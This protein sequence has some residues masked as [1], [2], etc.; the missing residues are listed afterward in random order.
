MHKVKPF[1]LPPFLFY[2]G[3]EK[4][5]FPFRES[6][7]LENKQVT[8]LVKSSNIESWQ[9]DIFV[10]NLFDPRINHMAE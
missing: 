2:F 1:N 7:N 6:K 10:K 9:R 3:K 4:G 8:T 5:N